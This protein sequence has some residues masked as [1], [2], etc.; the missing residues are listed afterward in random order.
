MWYG[1]KEFALGNLHETRF[2]GQSYNTMLE[3]IIAA[4]FY[5][6]G[7]DINK[8][9]PVVTC[10][11]SLFPFIFISIIQYVKG[12]TKSAL[13]II[14]LPLILPINYSLIT[15]IPRG[16]VTGIFFSS[17]LFMFVIKEGSRINYFLAFFLL[18]LSYSVNPNAVLFSIPCIV[19]LI[20]NNY[21]NKN[22]YKPALFGLGIGILTHYL[23]NLFYLLHPNYNLHN[24]SLKYSFKNILTGIQNLNL[25]F[26]DIGIISNDSGISTLLLLCV[27]T[28]FL[29]IKK[30]RIKS[31]SI[32]VT[33]IIILFSLSM[34]KIHDA[35]DSIFY[36]YSRMYL[37][38]PLTLALAISFI[39][40]KNKY[41]WLVYVYLL[42]PLLSVGINYQDLPQKIEQVTSTNKNHVV[43]IRK[44]EDIKEECR[45]LKKYANE[46]NIDLIIIGFDWRNTLCGYGCEACIDSFPK[47]LFPLYERRTW[48]MLEDAK[49]AYK[50]ILIIDVALRV[51]TLLA[52]AE[53]VDKQN[54]FYLIKN[55]HLKTFELLDSIGMKYR[56]Y[57]P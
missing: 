29:W 7:F 35:I 31:L 21:T 50:N 54:N 37:A 3:S 32:G 44:V 47:T 23:L 12:F 48:R 55:N 41:V 52:N 17:L 5:K 45:R 22:F 1:A 43:S 42:I 57:L 2:Y 4:P 53:N 40:I 16:F 51:D 27:I 30:E 18:V 25:F 26:G 34:D 13:L 6:M 20:L 46:K 19:Y 15:S 56:P 49:V 9:L 14:S 28:I 8:V 33:L 36:S 38:L 10:L 39:E 11:L 24:Y